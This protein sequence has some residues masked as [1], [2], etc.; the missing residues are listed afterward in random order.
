MFELIDDSDTNRN[1]RNV[2][3]WGSIGVA[4]LLVILSGILHHDLLE[5]ILV[6]SIFLIGPREYWK[7]MNEYWTSRLWVIIRI[8]PPVLMAVAG[9][10]HWRFFF[11]ISLIGS[12]LVLIGLENYL[13]RRT[14]NREQLAETDEVQK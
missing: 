10:Y 13:K 6:P 11:W 14:G 9:W 8:I 1:W 5:V 3:V 4:F 12:T 2:F 7:R